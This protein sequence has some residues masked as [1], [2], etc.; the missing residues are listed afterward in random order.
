MPLTLL[1]LA[2]KVDSLADRLP[3]VANDIVKDA[4]IAVITDL[5]HFTLVDT[6]RAVSN[7]Q[8]G[9]GSPNH[10]ARE[11][12]S[13]G[14]HGSTAGESAAATIEAARAIIAAKP[15]GVP[16]YISNAVSYIGYL[17]DGTEYIAPQGYT[18]RA[19]IVAREA[20]KGYNVVV[21][22]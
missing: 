7:W 13:P 17:N 20:I 14:I 3:T 19:P 1:D 22:I 6:S 2:T 5:A 9:I 10:A 21:S 12:H 15:P 16:L 18:E 8:V 4:A 11:P